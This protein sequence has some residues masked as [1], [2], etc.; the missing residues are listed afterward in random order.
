V[1]EYT[2]Y[3]FWDDLCEGEDDYD[4]YRM[5]PDGFEFQVGWPGGNFE[6]IPSGFADMD[7]LMNFAGGES[8]YEVVNVDG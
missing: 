1:S 6:W 7:D 5:G 3:K 2:Y 8:R 4:S